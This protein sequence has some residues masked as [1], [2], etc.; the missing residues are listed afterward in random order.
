MN[1]GD[2]NDKSRAVFWGY[3]QGENIASCLSTGKLDMNLHIYCFTSGIKA[4]KT[5]CVVHVVPNIEQLKAPISNKHG[6]NI[7]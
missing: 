6:I 1:C 2:L 7:H 5:I 3:E 4:T